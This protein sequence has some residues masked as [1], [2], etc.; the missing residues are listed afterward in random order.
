[1]LRAVCLFATILCSSQAFAQFSVDNAETTE[2]SVTFSL[3]NSIH[4]GEFAAGLPRSAH[5]LGVEWGVLHGWT[6]GFSVGIDNPRTGSPDVGTLEWSNKIAIIG[7]ESV[8]GF[9][10]GD[11]PR[12]GLIVD[13]MNVSAYA[14]F[15]V[16]TGA[17]DDVNLAVGPLVDLGVGPFLASINLLFDI[18]LGGGNETALIYAASVEYPVDDTFRVG[19]ESH[20]YI[21]RIFGTTPDYDDQ[22]H[23][24]GP[25]AT[26]TLGVA[27]NQ[28]VTL[29]FGGFL[30]ISAESPDFVASVNASLD[31]Y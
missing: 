10:R 27:E 17:S 8:I 16:D 21:E 19:I 11:E 15:S 2:N 7:T 12:R 28:D 4:T 20:S 24:I 3:D 22:L 23:L 26:L 25:T 30:G 29:R 14:G 6:S 18:P 1:M 9:T 31:L 5:S 13:V